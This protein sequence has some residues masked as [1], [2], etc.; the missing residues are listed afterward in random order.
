MRYDPRMDIAVLAKRLRVY[1]AE[2]HVTQIA[3]ARRLGISQTALSLL[4]N[5]K[6]CPQLDNA[7]LTHIQRTYNKQVTP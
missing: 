5:G 4:E 2:H 3:L 6:P 7:K 1:R